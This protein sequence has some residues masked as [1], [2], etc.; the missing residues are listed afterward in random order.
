VPKT[1]GVALREAL[2]PLGL[3][4]RCDGHMTTLATAQE[5]DVVTVVR[6]PIARY[7]SAFW[8]LAT[9]TLWPWASP[10][11]MAR[12]MGRSTLVDNAFKRYMVLWRQSHWIDAD[13]PLL[14]VGRTETLADDFARLRPL[15]GLTGDLPRRNV[16]RY[17][18][19]RLSE[20]ALDNLRAFYAED[21]DLLT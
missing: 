6:D 1:G 11:A 21:F 19:A 2:A 16:G 14:W 17:P 9:K 7:V 10:D 5:D 3:G 15:L 18:E 13:R 4:F 12:Q 20:P 8:W